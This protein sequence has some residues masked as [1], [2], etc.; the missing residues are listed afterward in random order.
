MGTLV[1]RVVAAEA[2]IAHAVAMAIG[3]STT[4]G[5]TIVLNGGMEF[6]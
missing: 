1:P 2:E 4:N 3:N 5:Q 6:I